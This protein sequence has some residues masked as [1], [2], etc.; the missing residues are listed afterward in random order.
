LGV[1]ALV[2]STVGIISLIDASSFYA[3]CVFLELFLFSLVFAHILLGW[4][5]EK[6]TAM[7]KLAEERKNREAMLEKE[8]ENKTSSLQQ[9]LKE[10]DTLL[11]EVHHRVKNNMQ[12]IMSLVRLQGDQIDGTE[13]AFEELEERIRAMAVV[14]EMLYQNGTFDVIDLHLYTDELVE[15]ISGSM[16]RELTFINRIP[17]VSFAAGRIIPLGL[18]ITECLINAFKHAV[19][20]GVL[21][22]EATFEK[23]GETYILS[24]KDNG[25]KAPDSYHRPGALGTDLIT[26]MARGKLQGSADISYNNGTEVKVRFHA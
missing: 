3:L 14:H 15:Q 2:L 8:I 21:Q 4:K 22:I 5:K 6:E 18:I 9:A 20:E 16:G 7:L 23:D 13:S 1:E 10:R 19:P 26:A 17:P 25:K 11:G 12:I 24:L